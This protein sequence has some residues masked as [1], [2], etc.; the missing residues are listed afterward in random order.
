MVGMWILKILQIASVTINFHCGIL[1]YVLITLW[2]KRNKS[3]AKTVM[4]TSTDMNRF[5][6]KD[7]KNQSYPPVLLFPT[8]LPG[9]SCTR[10][11]RVGITPPWASYQLRVTTYAAQQPLSHVLVDFWMKESQ[12]RAAKLKLKQ[13]ANKCTLKEMEKKL[14]NRLRDQRGL[15]EVFW[16]P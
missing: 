2:N 11:H 13:G 4:S 3:L 12:H 16:S 1:H 15:V 8:T 14:L 9:K 6:K 10:A 7:Q 5:L